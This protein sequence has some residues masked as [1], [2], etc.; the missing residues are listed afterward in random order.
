MNEDLY[1]PGKSIVP[2]VFRRKDVIE[3]FRRSMRG[4]FISNDFCLVWWWVVL[5][6][7]SLFY[8][9]SFIDNIQKPMP[10]FGR[11]LFSWPPHAYS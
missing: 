7:P 2:S 3:A 1:P 5:K 10:R 9:F 4:F 6:I 8:D 11:S